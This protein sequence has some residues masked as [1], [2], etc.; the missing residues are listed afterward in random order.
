MGGLDSPLYA[1]QNSSH[2]IRRTP[3]VLQ[4]VQTKL[5]SVVH[6]RVEHLA[7]EF[8]SWWFVRILLFKLHDKPESTVFKRGVCWADDDRVPSK[9][10]SATWIVP[11][12]Y[13]HT[14]S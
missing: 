3:T 14:K 2:V 9:C 7:D 4:Y 11:S 12:N 1:G 5:A 10:V 6:I 13:M 8:D